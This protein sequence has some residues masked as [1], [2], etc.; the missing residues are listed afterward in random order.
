M[1]RAEIEARVSGD[2]AWLLEQYLTLAPEDVIRPI[3]PSEHDPSTSWSAKDH[4]AHLSYVESR[5]NEMIRAHLGGDPNPLG[6]NWPEGSPTTGDEVRA[7]LRAMDQPWARVLMAGIHDELETW[8]LKQRTQ[9][10]SGVVALGQHVRAE[11]LA[12]LGTLTDMQLAELIPRSPFADGTIGG[13]I[14]NNGGHIR[15][16]WAW[17]DAAL[18]RRQ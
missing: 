8:T 11:T 10:F 5:F 15:G 3:T 18:A 12:L 16:H 13:L 14:A 7:G 2:R 6:W 17:I 4:L 9:S 1:D